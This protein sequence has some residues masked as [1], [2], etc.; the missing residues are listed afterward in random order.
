MELMS[1][2]S[3]DAGG[4]AEGAWGSETG[5]DGAE[6]ASLAE[7]T[8]ETWYHDWRGECSRELGWD[9][10]SMWIG[11]LRGYWIHQILA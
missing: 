11:R 7:M 6:R 8:G 9:V 2:F 5:D 1:T 10:M 3:V 4:G